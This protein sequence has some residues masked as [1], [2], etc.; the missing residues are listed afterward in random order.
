MP[1]FVRS[2]KFR[3]VFGAGSKRENSYDGM[4]VS[5]N[6]WETPY[7]AAN[8]KFIA[9]ILDSAGGGSF[10]VLPLEKVGNVLNEMSIL[11]FYQLCFSVPACCSNIQ[12]CVHGRS[13]VI[14][15]PDKCIVY[16]ESTIT[17][18]ACYYKSFLLL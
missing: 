1:N 8:P 5:R 12:W 18:K 10:L 15:V 2:S 11:L 13:L 14:S 4:K 3:H 16:N 9:I 7:C 17:F 6:S